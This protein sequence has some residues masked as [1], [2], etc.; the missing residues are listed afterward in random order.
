MHGEA[1]AGQF[2]RRRGNLRQGHGAKALK[3]RHQCAKRGW[4]TSRQKP[5]ARYEVQSLA[6]KPLGGCPLGSGGIAIDRRHLAGIRRVNQHRRLTAQGVHLW[7]QNALG[8]RRRHRRINR[9]AP[10]LQH[11]HPDQ[12]R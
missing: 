7:I 10:L 2:H 6:G 8:K 12:R 11:L 5:I 1:V 4:D 9:I 3:R